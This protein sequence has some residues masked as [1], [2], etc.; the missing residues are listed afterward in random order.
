MFP[1]VRNERLNPY[2]I[3]LQRIEWAI[4]GTLTWEDDARTK[5]TEPA[6]QLRR[7]DFKQF[8]EA[9]CGWVKIRS[10]E[11]PIYSKTEWGE[12]MRGHCNFLVGRQGTE[13]VAAERLSAVMI[14]IWKP[15][16]RAVIEPFNPRWQKEGVE[17]Q[18]KL[19]YDTNFQP[20]F[21]KEYSTPVLKAMLQKYADTETDVA[22]P[23][24]ETIFSRSR[25]VAREQNSV[26]GFTA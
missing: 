7:D 17:Y 14:E 26:A 15:T 22:A 21:P 11:L 1:V 24:F 19:E 23:D 18:S 10:R 5:Y 4:F 9:T 6:E 2:A 20:I 3:H 13:K 8:I 16:G 12:G 25:L